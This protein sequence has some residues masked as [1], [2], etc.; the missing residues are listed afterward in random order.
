MIR[1]LFKDS[2]YSLSV[3]LFQVYNLCSDRSLSKYLSFDRLEVNSSMFAQR[4]DVVFRKLIAFVDISADF[5]YKAFLSFCLWLRFYI[6]L[7]VGVGHGL[8]VTHDAGFGD[9]SD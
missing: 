4:A 9:S 1:I 7:V 6:V 8:L 5:A 2:A 3:W